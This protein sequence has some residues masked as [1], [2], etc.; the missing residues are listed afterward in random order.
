MF[1]RAID[2]MTPISAPTISNHTVT[3]RPVPK[4]HV[5]QVPPDVDALFS[6]L[7]VTWRVL[8]TDGLSPYVAVKLI[9]KVL[10]IWLWSGV[11]VKTP[12]DGSNAMFFSSP[13]AERTMGSP[14]RLGFEAEIVKL[15]L[16][17]T[18]AVSA[19]GA[20]I[21]GGVTAITVIVTD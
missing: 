2:D 21:I 18:V 10:P 7:M 12:V 20:V 13:V 4:M 19:P 8:D 15:R 9:V 16:L 11:N 3:D 6:A 14:A 1:K 5:G 17:P